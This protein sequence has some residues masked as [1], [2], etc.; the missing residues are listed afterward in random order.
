MGE[1]STIVSE[2]IVKLYNLLKA[3]REE[4]LETLQ[5]DPHL[6][7]N[8]KPPSLGSEDGLSVEISFRFSHSKTR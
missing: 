5:F 7:P 1:I 3:D 4:M 8:V 6:D 2:A